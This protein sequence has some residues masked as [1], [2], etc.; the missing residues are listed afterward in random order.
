MS[1]RNRSASVLLTALLTLAAG[2]ALPCAAVAQQDR[3]PAPAAAGDSAFEALVLSGGGSRGLAHVGA[4]LELERLGHDPDLVVGT[5]IGALV[6]ALYAAGYPPEEIARRV[7]EVDWGE[8]FTPAPQLAGPD[9]EARYPLIVYDLQT[10]TL[11]FNRGFIPQWRINR[12]LVRLLFDAEARSRGDFD[13]LARRYRAVAADLR[14]G[15]AVALSRGD[16]PRAA[17]ASM[18]VPGVFSPVVWE[19]R[20]LIDGGIA[21]NLPTEVARRLGA[22][23]IVA[24]DVG[25]PGPEIG[26]RGP[27]MVA[28]RAIDLMHQNAD[29]GDPPPDVLVVPRLDPTFFGIT[30]PADPEPLF[31]LGRE[32][33]RQAPPAARRRPG[34]R[35][36]PPAPRGFGALRIEAPDSASASLARRIFR[37]VAPGAY[38]PA[39]VLAAVDRLYTTGLFEGVWPRVEASGAA[40]ALPELVVRLEAPPRL[41]L[42]GSAGYDTDAGDGCGARCSATA[43]CSAPRRCLRPPPGW[44]ACGSGARCRRRRTGLARRRWCG[45]RARTGAKPTCAATWM[46]RRVATP[47]SG[48]WEAGWGW[49]SSRCWR[50]GW[51]RP[52]C[53]RSGSWWRTGAADSPPARTFAWPL[54]RRIIPWSAC[55]SSWRRRRAGASSRTGARRC[56]VRSRGASG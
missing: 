17:R 25:R 47:T 56:A 38:D 52:R 36:L 31:R 42:A 19:G 39:R 54:P 30:F 41:T 10:D 12:L 51:D 22:T 44:T 37:G 45:A 1:R 13:R 24:V 46:T 49:N 32:A 48:A 6:G 15:E 26:S 40:D 55:P 11:R 3:G 8:V 50:N 33:A 5:S 14:T 28:G 20:S 7:T 2:L 34:P 21:S 27:L 18:A 23:R 43:P 4:V 16:L 29:R 53:A 9:R 35:P